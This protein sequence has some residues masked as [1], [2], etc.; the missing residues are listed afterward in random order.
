MG[1]TPPCVPRDAHHRDA[2]VIMRTHAVVVVVVVS[3]RS[4]DL[5]RFVEKWLMRAAFDDA[6][7]PWLPKEVLWRQKE[8][9]SDGV[10]YDWIDGLKARRRSVVVAPAR[11]VARS[12]PRVVVVI[13]AT[14]R[15]PP[16]STCRAS[17][18][19]PPLG[20]VTFGGVAG[21][22]RSSLRSVMCVCVFV[23]PLDGT[24]CVV[25]HG[26]AG[27]RVQRHL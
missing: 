15:S 12:V 7:R 4:I 10:G 1:V 6:A 13:V 11:R 18:A 19:A 21:R 3:D 9:F 27:A 16:S 24:S 8:Q 23:A 20:V 25:A 14:K 5:R 22:R 2:P 17:G 26:P